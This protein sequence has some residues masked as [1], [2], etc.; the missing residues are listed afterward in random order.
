MKKKFKPAFIGIKECLQD[1]SIRIQ[2]IFG[3]VTCIVA[4]IFQATLI[5]YALILSAVFLVIVSEVFN[6]CIERVCDLYSKELDERIR[7]IKD[8]SASAVLLSALYAIC[9]AFIIFLHHYGGV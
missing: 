3:I 9:I 1:K 5:E 6:T 7:Y 8:M 4:F 2:I